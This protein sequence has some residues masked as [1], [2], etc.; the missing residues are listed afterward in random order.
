MGRR[1]SPENLSGGRNSKD[2]RNAALNLLKAL[3]NY[4]YHFSKD[5]YVYGNM[6]MKIVHR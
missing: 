6:F 3:K 4:N 2:H 5:I 1:K